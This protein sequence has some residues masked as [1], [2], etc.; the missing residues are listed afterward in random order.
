M[1]LA[2]AAEL[3]ADQIAYFERRDCFQ[4]LYLFIAD[5]LA[6]GSDRRLHGK[7]GQDLEQV[8]WITSRIS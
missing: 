7:I 3:P 5:R 8:F 1:L 6:V 4:H 2:I